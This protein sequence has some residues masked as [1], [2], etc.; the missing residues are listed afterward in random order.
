MTKQ[1]SMV[2]TG[3]LCVII[4][5]VPRFLFFFSFFLSL[6]LFIFFFAAFSVIEGNYKG[7]LQKK[8]KKNKNNK[9]TA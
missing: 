9:M 6:F 1:T 5:I 7:C 3:S 8:I 2:V 4:F